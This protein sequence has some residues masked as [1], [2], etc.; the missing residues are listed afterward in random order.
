M[1]SRG[2]LYFNDITNLFFIKYLVI[3]F[4]NGTGVLYRKY[5]ATFEY[6]V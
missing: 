3:L 6:I 4:V 1:N 2:I 5:G